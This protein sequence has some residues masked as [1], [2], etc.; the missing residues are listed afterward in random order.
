MIHQ[1]TW[2]IEQGDMLTDYRLTTEAYYGMLTE[3]VALVENLTEAGFL[4]PAGGRNIDRII[5]P[6]YDRHSLLR[7]T[8]LPP[9]DRI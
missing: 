3:F 8:I 5:H 6:V 1:A 9:E 4:S 2:L 7:N